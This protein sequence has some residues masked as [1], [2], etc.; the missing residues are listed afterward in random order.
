[1]STT[2]VNV[3]KDYAAFL[4]AKT[5]PGVT[6][7]GDY[8]ILPA[9]D[10]INA[11]VA[12]SLEG[13]APH[14]HEYQKFAVTF[15]VARQRSAL[16]LECGLGKTSIALAWVEHVRRG[17]PAMVCAPLAALH[18]FENERDRFFPSIPLKI[19]P[20][21]DVAAWLDDPSGIALVTHHAFVRERDLSNVG[22][23]VLDE[24][25][26]LKSGD[27]VIARNLV[28]ACQH[29]TFKIAL[30]ATPAPND[31]TEYAT[32]AT[33]LGYMRSDAEFRAR[34]FVRD[35]REWRVK[36]HAKAALPKWLARFALWMS[37]PAAYGMPCDA[38]PDEDY[39]IRYHELP[40]T[41][42][43]E[44]ERD[45][46]GAPAGAMT[47]GAR[48]RLRRDLYADP[49]RQSAV[50]HW[51]DGPTIV[52]TIR[53]A[54]ADVIERYLAGAGFRVRQ[55][56]G[57][58]S[59]EDRVSAI[60]AF[61]GGNVD[62]LVSKP[63]VIGHGV[64]LQHAQRMVFAGYDESYEA[65]HQ[66]VRRAHRQGRKGQL[67][68]VVLTAPEEVGVISTLD[69][70]AD[71]WQ[72]DSARQ[73]S[74]F[75]TALERDINAYHRGEAMT[76]YTDEHE[77][78]E[79]AEGEHYRVIHGDCIDEMAL[80]EPE[81]VDLSVFSP[82]FASLFTYSSEH[83]DMG[84]CSDNGDA[85]FNL[86]F[87]HFA[88]ALHRVMRPGRVVA[89]HLAQ[90]VAFRARHGRKGIRDFRGTVITAMED[91]GFHFYGEFVI[92]KNPQ[93]AA[94]RT[95][96]ERLQFV[97]FKRDSLESSPALND[98]VLEFRKPGTQTVKVNNDVTNEEWI[99]WASGVWHDIRETDVLSYHKAR[100]DNDE[101]H[102]CPLQ[103]SVIERI[104]RLWSNPGEVVF[105]PFA[106][107]GSEV[108][109]A[110]R[111]RRFG[112]GIELK[113]EYF[114]QAAKACVRAESETYHQ[115]SL[116]I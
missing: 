12:E 77:R 13:H 1:V 91:S 24:S 75:V 29:I 114:E 52:W 82:P 15:S 21:G 85:E 104:V 69:A 76:T 51:C 41:E 49:V 31:P 65:F 100:G 9:W 36:G 2:R 60:R 99:R 93:A 35:G 47:M 38:L 64:N 71:Q 45:L 63:S 3:R 40:N 106:G 112:L 5:L 4:S 14:L 105:S 110:I 81:S 59:D 30:S 62:V 46:F 108:Y 88:D 16:F 87:A 33:W 67:E 96:S 48:S 95:K 86:H 17:S 89:L 107:I 61:Q 37:D 98:Y 42:S 92:P 109:T 28:S 54:H 80:M 58:T 84:N 44:L 27:G 55:I 25:S 102:I 70:K 22:A 53:N 72:I 83:A 79:P 32:H 68:V 111:Q 113:A 39:A 94:I 19:V 11:D 43:A 23:F 50:R 6:Y 116:E 66:A 57:V 26:I 7:D 78:I 10:N 74:E 34:F 56:A 115:T 97:Q 90:L 18:E 73:E 103:L 101:K 20:T 8:A